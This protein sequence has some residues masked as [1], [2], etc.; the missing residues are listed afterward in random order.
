MRK[1]FGFPFL[2]LGISSFW[3]YCKIAGI[4]GF[5]GEY[6]AGDSDDQQDS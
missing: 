1:F 6:V 3:M 5:M 4:E 2:V